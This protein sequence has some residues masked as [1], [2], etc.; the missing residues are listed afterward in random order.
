MGGQ[1]D[2][3]HACARWEMHRIWEEAMLRNM[4]PTLVPRREPSPES[5]SSMIT[6]G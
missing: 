6:N 1:A 3:R 5:I 4:Q 2:T